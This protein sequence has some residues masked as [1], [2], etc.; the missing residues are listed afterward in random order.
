MRERITTDPAVRL[1]AEDVRAVLTDAACVV[2]ARA[3][4]GANYQD[5]NRG[6]APT[7][8]TVDRIRHARLNRKV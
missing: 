5:W 2:S 6:P 1:E 4:P 7:R 8:P 3:S